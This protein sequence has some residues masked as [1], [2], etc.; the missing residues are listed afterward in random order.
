LIPAAQAYTETKEE[1]LGQAV[2]IKK[3]SA[4]RPFPSQ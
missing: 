2:Q 1:L 3:V 4:C